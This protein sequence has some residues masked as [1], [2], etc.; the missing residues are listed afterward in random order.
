M[1]VV[2]A[3]RWGA[4]VPLVPTLLR[5]FTLVGRSEVGLEPDRGAIFGD[6]LRQLPPVLQIDAAVVISNSV[7]PLLP[8]SF[9]EPQ[10]P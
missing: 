5:R 8:L 6:R 9:P 10:A 7:G 1:R 3:G 4:S 2:R